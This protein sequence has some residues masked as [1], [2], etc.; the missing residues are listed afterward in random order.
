MGLFEETERCIALVAAG[1]ILSAPAL[2]LFA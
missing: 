2:K 1:N